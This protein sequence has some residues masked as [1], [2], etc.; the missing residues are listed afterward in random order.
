MK[1]LRSY[2][3]SLD[4]EHWSTYNALSRGK[5]KMKY[6]YE[7]DMEISYLAIKCR[8]NGAVFT[9]DDFK[10]NAKYRGIEFAYCGMVI[11]S[12]EFEGVITGYNSSCN[13]N[14][15]IT[16]GNFKGQYLSFHPNWKI[17]YYDKNG[18]LIKEFI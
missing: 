9:S 2:E 3:C 18:D 4:G 16:N 17:A 8:V 1:E 14:V 13:L 11:K 7:L 6:Y 10:R 12:E 15:L 5:A